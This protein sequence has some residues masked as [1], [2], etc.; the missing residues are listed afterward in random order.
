[1]VYCTQA[2]RSL[3]ELFPI[4]FVCIVVHLWV[5]TCCN[6]LPF[7]F[8]LVI[9]IFPFLVP[10]IG[11]RFVFAPWPKKIEKKKKEEKKKEEKKKKKQPSAVASY[12]GHSPPVDE[13]TALSS[14][15]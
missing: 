4:V 14:Q 5:C 12:L 2:C 11:N 1:M 7:P 10:C 9:I 13:Y 15:K 3:G 8:E 6:F